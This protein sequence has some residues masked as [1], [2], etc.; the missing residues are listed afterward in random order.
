MPI[1]LWCVLIAAL[2]PYVCIQIARFTGPRRDNRQ[3]RQWAAGLTDVAQR[4]NGAQQNHFEVFPF[5]AV[6]VLVA[7]LGGSPVDRVNG[8]AVA[9]IAVRVLYT[10]CYL[11]NWATA[12]S[13]VWTVGLVLTI[14]LF[15]QPAFVH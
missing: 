15:V 6:A 10:V 7:I 1:A 13:L 4:A 14:A 12:R 11:A 5:F 9:F 3:P 2:L 8:L